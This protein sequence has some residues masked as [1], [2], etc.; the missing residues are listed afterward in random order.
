MQWMRASFCL[1]LYFFD[2]TNDT[3]YLYEGLKVIVVITFRSSWLASCLIAFGFCFY[4]RSC[5][6]H[7]R[8]W[9]S[10]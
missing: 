2:A 7:R 10:T 6:D 4:F 3:T 8:I 9:L 5:A 1:I